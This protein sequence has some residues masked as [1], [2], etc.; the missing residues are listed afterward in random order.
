MDL[1]TEPRFKTETDVTL[2]LLR[3]RM[4]ELPGRIVDVSGVGFRMI[5]KEPLASGEPVRIK[6]GDLH[7]LALVRYC[8]PNTGGYFIG[9]ERIDEWVS[10]DTALHP[11]IETKEDSI[12]V[13]GRPM[14][15]GYL[16]QLRTFALRDMFFRASRKRSA[17]PL[18]L[19]GVAA[20]ISIAALALY[21]SGGLGSQSHAVAAATTEPENATPPAIT[22]ISGQTEQNAQDSPAGESK[23]PEQATAPVAPGSASL[24][25]PPQQL[26]PLVGGEEPQKNTPANRITILAS[27]M[28]WVD[29]CADG[30]KILSK[31]LRANEMS[32]FTFVRV[33]TVRSGN[34]GALEITFSSKLPARM[35]NGGSVRMWRFTPDGYEEVPTTSPSACTAP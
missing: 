4:R 22:N 5:V 19:G 17:T 6:A 30:R 20:T 24:S 33:A 15:K 3:N 23:Q 2:Q 12:R 10:D 14:L 35:G 7:L 26:L 9:V 28:S 29:A 34:A 25:D 8:V 18:A 13:I 32:E 21:L 11:A 1:R 16:G 27:G 31:A